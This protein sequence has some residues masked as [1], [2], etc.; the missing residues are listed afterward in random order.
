MPNNTI[1]SKAQAFQSGYRA[2]MAGKSP[3]SC[4]F[5]T[6]IMV[7]TWQRG[8]ADYKRKMKDAKK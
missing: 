5:K 3:D 8:F 7:A 2:A 6:P 4:A 1:T